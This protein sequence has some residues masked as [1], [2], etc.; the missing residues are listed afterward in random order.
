MGIFVPTSKSQ[1]PSSLVYTSVCSLYVC[2][3]EP[4]WRVLFLLKVIWLIS[5][6]ILQPVKWFESWRC[7]SNTASLPPSHDSYD[8]NLTLKKKNQIRLEQLQS[9]FLVYVII[10]TTLIYLVPYSTSYLISC[11]SEIKISTLQGLYIDLPLSIH[12][13]MQGKEISLAWFIYKANFH[14][15]PFSILLALDK[16]H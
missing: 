15:A 5:V 2:V 3:F 11:L 13:V 8:S 7:P 9:T 4:E 1:Y 10:Q 12:I 16:S 14:F 6:C